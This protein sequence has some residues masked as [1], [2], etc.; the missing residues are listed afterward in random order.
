MG[1]G[2]CLLAALHPEGTFLGIDFNP[3]HISHAEGLRGRLA[4]TNVR[5]LEADFVALAADPA[6]LGPA[7][8][9]GGGFHYVVAHGIATWISEPIQAAL[10]QLASAALNPGGILYCSYNTFPGWLGATAFQ[11]FAEAQRRRVVADQKAAASRGSKQIKIP[12][13]DHDGR[14]QRNQRSHLQHDPARGGHDTV[15]FS[16]PRCN[17]QRT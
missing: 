13:H 8:A 6:P 3:A 17:P 4:L 14:A 9:F 2:L 16:M 1:F 15:P 12:A 7:P 11:E 10:L 5:F